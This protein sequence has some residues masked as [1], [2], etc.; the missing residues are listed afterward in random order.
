MFE[1]FYILIDGII[2][3]KHGNERLTLSLFTGDLDKSLAFFKSHVANFLLA[4]NAEGAFVD[5]MP[6][7]PPY[8]FFIQLFHVG[9]KGWADTTAQ[10]LVIFF[11][12]LFGF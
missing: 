6:D 2:A 1:Q 5:G 12:P 10:S 4:K 3:G 8:A 11:S 9:G 7:I